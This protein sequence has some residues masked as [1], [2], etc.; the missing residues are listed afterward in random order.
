MKRQVAFLVPRRKEVVV[1]QL[2]DELL[3]YDE[4]SNRAHCLNH[5]AAEVWKQ[6][7]GANTVG[8]IVR[9]LQEMPSPLQEEVVLLTLQRLQRAG[10]LFGMP[11]MGERQLSRRLIL[12]RAGTVAGL[13]LP[14]VTSILVPTPA[15]AA[16]PCRH[17]L[18]PCP[19]GNTQCCSGVCVVGLCV[20][21]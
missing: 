6:C 5:T 4:Q 3:V 20:G 15:E 14:M 7:D 2:S 16:S 17:A 19:R 12:R 21:G 1:R 18:S 11:E 8:Q 10:V 13:L 9:R